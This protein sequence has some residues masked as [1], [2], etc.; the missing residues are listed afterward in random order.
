MLGPTCFIV[1]INDIDE[2]L[3]LVDGFVYKFADDT[4]YGRVVHDDADRA[5]MQ[6][7][8]DRLMEW[9]ERWQMELNAKK[10]KSCMSG[11]VTPV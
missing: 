7:D 5:I 10:C 4:K 9:A 2:V 8:I 1:F 11:V 3:E 6:R